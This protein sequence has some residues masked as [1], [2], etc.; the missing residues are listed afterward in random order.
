MHFPEGLEDTPL[1]SCKSHSKN[2]T[3]NIRLLVFSF[4]SINWAFWCFLFCFFMW[5]ALFQILLCEPQSIWRKL[6]VMSWLYDN[7]IFSHSVY[8]WSFRLPI[9]FSLELRV[10]SACLLFRVLFEQ[11][12]PF[13]AAFGLLTLP[14]FSTWSK[15]KYIKAKLI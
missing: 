6:L 4:S 12:L 7:S 10:F 8:L 1:K 3:K 5:F 14:Q 11:L 2:E 15:K 9:R 13:F